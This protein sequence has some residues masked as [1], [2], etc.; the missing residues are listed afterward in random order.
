VGVAITVATCGADV[1]IGLAIVSYLEPRGIATAVAAG[2]RAAASA[3]AAAVGP[4]LMTAV[5]DAICEAIP[6][7][8]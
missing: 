3:A 8:C 1:D 5:I 4:G 7:A 2:A 6:N